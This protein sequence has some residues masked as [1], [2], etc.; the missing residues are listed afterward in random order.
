MD[1][2]H[3]PLSSHRSLFT[4]NIRS[5]STTLQQSPPVTKQCSTRYCSIH[6]FSPL[7]RL[8]CKSFFPT[9]YSYHYRS[10]A[11]IYSTGT[12]LVPAI[13]CTLFIHIPDTTYLRPLLFHLLLFF[14]FPLLFF[15]QQPSSVQSTGS[16]A[17]VYLYV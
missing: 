17:S 2:V 4:Y 14:F 8:D 6:F 7:L 15:L 11:A 12:L 10:T 3:T 1:T 5:R 16:P 13:A 9:G